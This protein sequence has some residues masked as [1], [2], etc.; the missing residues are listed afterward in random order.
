MQYENEKITYLFNIQISAFAS[1]YLNVKQVIIDYVFCHIT[2]RNYIHWF[3][4]H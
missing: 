2:C 4:D 3:L 1:P